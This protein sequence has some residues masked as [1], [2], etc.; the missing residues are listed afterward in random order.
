ELE[1]ARRVGRFEDEGWRLRKDGTR[2]WA[3]VLIT[4]IRH[5]DGQLFGFSKITRDL[6]ERRENEERLRRS[7]E[8]LRHSEER[9]RLLLEGI[10]DYAI[11]MLDPEGRVSSW[12]TGAQNF[13]GYRPA[14]VIG[15][16]FER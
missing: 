7:E 4:A 12:N 8:R 3:S 13:L 16:S 14:E 5:D 1:T 15:Q 9:F 10:S 6:T 11:M 2:F